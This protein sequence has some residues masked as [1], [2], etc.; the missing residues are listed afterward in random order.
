MIWGQPFPVRV[1]YAE[2]SDP[3][4]EPLSTTAP[5]LPIYDVLPE[6]DVRIPIE[7][8]HEP[9]QARAK[10]D[11]P[12]LRLVPEVGEAVKALVKSLPVSLLSFQGDGGDTTGQLY[13]EIKVT[14]KLFL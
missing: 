1:P 8:V 14:A 10:H 7:R 3:T 2:G 12:L 11:H 5:V 13:R 9:T 6:S 4:R